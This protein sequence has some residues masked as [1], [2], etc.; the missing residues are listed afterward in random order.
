[1]K[2]ERLP[3]AARLLRGAEFSAVLSTR[4]KQANRHFRIFTASTDAHPG[5]CPGEARLGLAIAK[6]VARRAVDRNRLRRLA[7]ESF[8]RR[9]AR[10]QPGDYVVMAN[11][12]AV[13][14][15]NPTLIRALDQ[16]WQRFEI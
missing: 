11:P 5:N 7:R 14:A 12:A 9:R 2:S 8:R 4:Q 16:L 15:D 10:L 3:R 13:E 1:M 6:K